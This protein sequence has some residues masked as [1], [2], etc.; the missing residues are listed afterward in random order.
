MYFHFLK[1]TQTP[2]PRGRSNHYRL[3]CV[4]TRKTTSCVEN[5]KFVS[6]LPK[7]NA[8]H[9][10][11][12]RT[13]IATS[14]TLLNVAPAVVV[15]SWES[16]TTNTRRAWNH[17]SIP[18]F[19]RLTIDIARASRS[20]PLVGP[21]V[22]VQRVRVETD[23]GPGTTAWAT[24]RRVCNVVKRS[25]VTR[26]KYKLFKYS[27]RG[28][29]AGTVGS[30]RFAT[31]DGVGRGLGPIDSTIDLPLQR[32]VCVSSARTWTRSSVYLYNDLR[33]LTIYDPNAYTLVM[34]A[35]NNPH[36]WTR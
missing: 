16:C 22:G 14:N 32:L 34:R 27:E 35:C 24:C 33:T 12:A 28:S 20:R 29:G 2:E 7:R 15:S 11:W 19:F 25:F 9:C 8:D 4:Q 17:L 1:Q 5:L 30:G 10:R 18:A 23:V 26:Y 36:P 13:G 21:T 31:R 3:N 6:Y